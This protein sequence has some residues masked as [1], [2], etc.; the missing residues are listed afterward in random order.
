MMRNTNPLAGPV[1]REEGPPPNVA[2][3]PAPEDSR[4]FGQDMFDHE[5]PGGHAHDQRVNTPAKETTRNPTHGISACTGL[6]PKRDDGR[7]RHIFPGP[8]ISTAK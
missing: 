8:G 4:S 2:S 5:G 6:A 1:T 3:G 7:E